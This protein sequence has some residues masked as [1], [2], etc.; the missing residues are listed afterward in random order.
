MKRRPE[1][2]SIDEVIKVTGLKRRILPFV[3]ESQKLV[4]GGPLRARMPK[5]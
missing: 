2:R 4:T 5:E 3:C 1:K